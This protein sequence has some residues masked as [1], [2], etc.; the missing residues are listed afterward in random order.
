M[1]TSTVVAGTASLTTGTPSACIKEGVMTCESSCLSGAGANPSLS[2]TVG[3]MPGTSHSSG[4]ENRTG[5]LPLATMG[6]PVG[7]T[8]G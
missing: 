1:L 3:V 8:T 7:T 5:S 2:S 4:T 6:S